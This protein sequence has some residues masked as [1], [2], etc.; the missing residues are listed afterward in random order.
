MSE[1]AEMLD[2]SFGFAY[3]IFHKDLGYQK[4]CVK[5]VPKQMTETHKRQRKEA[6]TLFLQNHEV[7]RFIGEDCHWQQDV[8]A[9]L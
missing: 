7:S 6:A 2:I 5:F 4:V 3:T 9:P 8:G 1:V